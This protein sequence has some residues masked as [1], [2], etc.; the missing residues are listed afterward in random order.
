MESLATT[1]TSKLGKRTQIFVWG[2]TILFANLSLKAQTINHDYVDGEIW[3]KLKE[4]QFVPV[5]YDATSDEVTSFNIINRIAEKYQLEEIA[6]PF[7]KAESQI[8][9]RILKVRFG[10]YSGV[11]DLIRE[12]ENL[13]IV[14]Y[15]EH[16][17]MCYSNFSPNDV[18]YSSQW[19]L[20][21]IN[22]PAAWD[23]STGSNKIIVAIVDGGVEATHN[24][25][26]SQIWVNTGE[27]PN[28]GIDNDGN[29]WVDDV[30]GF[31]VADND[32]NVIPLPVSLHG[33]HCAGIVSATGNNSTGI[34]SIGMNLTIMP[35]KAGRDA[36]ASSG[37]LTSGF[38]GIYYATQN[39]AKII[40]CSWSNGTMSTSEKALLD[41]A[42]LRGAIVV[43]AAGNGGC[44]CQSYPSALSNVVSVA[45]TNSSDVLAA[46]SSY[47]SSVDICA[48]G[49]GILSTVTNNGYAS[50]SGTS[51]STPLVAGLLGLMY[52]VNP[53]LT[54]AQLLNCLYSTAVNIDAQ[55]P[56]KTGM[57]GAGRIDAYAALQCVQA[58]VHSFDASLTQVTKLN[59]TCLTQF[60]LQVLISN[61][62]T[63][64]LTSL[65]INYKT[66]SGSPSV[67]NW[68][69]NIS[70][71]AVAAVT[72]PNVTY[73]YG[74]HIVTIYC[75]APN[76]SADQNNLNDT[77]KTTFNVIQKGLSLPFTEDF[78]NVFPP[79]NWLVTAG[80]PIV[81]SQTSAAS[82]SGTKC[83]Y[84]D[85]AADPFQNV[86][87]LLTTPMID[88]STVAN[89]ELT[90]AIAYQPSTSTN[91]TDSFSVWAASDCSSN[92]KLIYRKGGDILSTVPGNA[93]VVFKPSGPS[94]WRK[95]TVKLTGAIATSKT[96]KFI[97]QNWHIINGNKLYLDDI[98]ID[99]TLTTGIAD[100]ENN[101]NVKVY[102]NPNNGNFILSAE[103]LPIDT[104]SVE[105]MNMMGQ[106]VYIKAISNTGS[107]YYENIQLNDMANGVYTLKVKG[108]S[109][110]W[111]S[112]FT[113]E[114][115]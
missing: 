66:D 98:K 5:S 23:I 48:P 9:N 30:N 28:D 33:T 112:R 50:L 31:D 67:Y 105:I 77:I 99:N 14:E 89:P 101:V 106:V 38:Q 10:N 36:D 79:S 87:D 62:G 76:G 53:N 2:L 63:S 24:D 52:S 26:K 81:W 35:V 51:M 71:G 65:K 37:Y 44:N 85:N 57:L 113:A 92:Y 88:L 29:G 56:T 42:T 73:G 55:N 60:P 100:Q 8:L 103:H 59:E 7:Y 70:S 39:K 68:S 78:E 83:A 94:Q 27:I 54:P 13:D 93:T 49:E 22:A 72:L 21:K 95:E 58:T 107:L 3:L 84:I 114:N 61:V 69:G 25:L 115:K 16:V 1:S 34:A 102:P 111:T 47:S 17:S 82:Y 96:A 20:T 11:N 108:A 12:L 97:F 109:G 6:S 90:F 43:G 80:H 41:Y 64:A 75:S 15:A 45:N 4:N 104:Y 18:Q 32:K 110:Q 46:T 74:N 40:S 86:Q 91:Y 19:A